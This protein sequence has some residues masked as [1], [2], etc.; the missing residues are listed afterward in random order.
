MLNTVILQTM[1]PRKFRWSKDYESAEEE[2][3]QLFH[4]KHIQAKRI[5]IEPDE[6]F[7]HKLVQPSHLWCA[8]G[9]C[10]ISVSGVVISMQPGDALDIPKDT[11]LDGTGGMTGCAYYLQESGVP[12]V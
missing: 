7:S 3:I 1:T 8:E 11:T 10:T 2:L 5:H 6:H 12:Q 9:S 4:A